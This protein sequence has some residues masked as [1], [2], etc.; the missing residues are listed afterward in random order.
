MQ[1]QPQLVSLGNTDVEV[2]PMGTGTM[3]WGER[4]LLG[5]SRSGYAED[6][7]RGTFDASIVAGINFFDTAEVY[8]R[9]QSERLLGRFIRESGRE[10]VV[11][12]KFMPFPWRWTRSG[13]LHAL[14]RSLKRLGMS[15]VDLYQMHW[16][17]PPVSIKARMN[18]LADAVEAGLTRAVGVSNYNVSQMRQAHEALARRGVPLASNQVIYNLMDC[19]PKRRALLA[20]CHELNVTFIAYSPLATGMLTGKYAPGNSPSDIRRFRFG[21][22]L[23]RM[24]SLI[25]LLRKIGEECGDKTPAQVALNW[26][27]CKGAVP[28]PGSKNARQAQENAGAAGW[29]L[30]DAQVAELEEVAAGV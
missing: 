5:S 7:A 30:S 6:D 22:R 1:Q 14:R 25:S 16:P 18:A 8:G 2:P 15:R 20:A 10:V 29:R 26:V 27:M 21:H 24:Q 9:G 4:H 11:A 3:V 17:M 19:G 23:A 12:T 28:I 13:L